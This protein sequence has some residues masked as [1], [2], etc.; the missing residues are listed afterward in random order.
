MKTPICD[1]V[2]DY[3]ASGTVRMHMPGHKGAGTQAHEAGAEALGDA[4]DSA[5]GSATETPDRYSSAFS[6]IAAYDITEIKGSDELYHPTSIIAESEKNA[7]AIFGCPTYYSTEGSSLCIRAML[8]L[9]MMRARS[10]NDAKNSSG[11]NTKNAG[12][13][14]D[15]NTQKKP[16]VLAARNVHESFVSACALLD[17]D[18]EWIASKSGTLISV[19]IDADDVAKALV[20]G[21]SSH[22]SDPCC[23]YITS[24]DYA[25]HILPV[26]EIA[27][28]CH[29]N[30]IALV[31][32][33]AHGAY[34]K[35]LSESQHPMDLGADMCCDSA[36]KTLPVLTGGAYLHVREDWKRE[37]APL[38]FLVKNAMRMF[39]STSPSWLI[40]QSLDRANL[41]LT[42]GGSRS[43][44][45]TEEKVGTIREAFTGIGLSCYGEDTMRI[46]ILT[47]PFGYTG[48]EFASI[49]REKKIEVEFSDP[50]MIVLMITP[51]N[52]GRDLDKLSKTLMS[53]PKKDALP[54]FRES[55]GSDENDE[56]IFPQKKFTIRGASMR[57]WETVPMKEA[58]GRIAAMGSFSCP[59]AIPIVMPGEVIGEREIKQFE[60]YGYN[61]CKVIQ[62]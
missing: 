1:F 8:Y 54:S 3:A 59:P 32:D 60:Y 55:V 18:A 37:K 10:E 2:R 33:N 58:L 20:S 7:S 40:L 51:K 13:E 16:W 39:A 47:R 22:N 45:K 26:K 50:D 30:G 44:A 6:N 11:A 28:V 57:P 53:I 62:K 42:Q 4:G 29:R 31:V 38:S 23:V 35:F 36:H 48:D 15:K 49:L 34:L 17:I 52:T 41:W 14:S 9:N 21:I 24:P 5:E 56:Q 19:D 43:F 27:E 12:S 46:T 25:G 61:E